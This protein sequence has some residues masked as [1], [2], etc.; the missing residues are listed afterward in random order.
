M[1]FPWANKDTH[2]LI[3]I[4]LILTQVWH[5]ITMGVQYEFQIKYISQ[6]ELHLPTK[7]CLRLVC[8]K[9]FANSKFS[10]FRALWSPEPNVCTNTTKLWPWHP[11]T[12]LCLN[13]ALQ[14]AGKEYRTNVPDFVLC[15]A[16]NKQCPLTIPVWKIANNSSCAHFLV[17][18]CSKRYGNWR[19]ILDMEMWNLGHFAHSFLDKNFMACRSVSLK[20]NTFLAFLPGYIIKMNTDKKIVKFEKVKCNNF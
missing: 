4:R 20:S 10:S 3:G 5:G 14:R 18:I 16:S 7:I 1:L 13:F 2:K 8:S 19:H 17:V 11:Q 15:R 9:K 12:T 6:M